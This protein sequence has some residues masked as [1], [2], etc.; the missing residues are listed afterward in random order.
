MVLVHTA[1]NHNYTHNGTVSL[2]VHQFLLLYFFCAVICTVK[3]WKC[4]HLRTRAK[5]FALGGVHITWV[6]TMRGFTVHTIKIW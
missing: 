1:A 3:P 4:E 2:D 5:V 6:F